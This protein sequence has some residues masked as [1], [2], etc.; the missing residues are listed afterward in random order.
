MCS[1]SRSSVPTRANI[2]PSHITDTISDNPMDRDSKNTLEASNTLDITLIAN[3]T[4]KTKCTLEDK[5]TTWYIQCQPL[6][7]HVF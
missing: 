1:L 2:S 7:L 3:N 6:P 5:N 4:L